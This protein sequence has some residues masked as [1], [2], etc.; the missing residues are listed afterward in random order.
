MIPL[1][2]K[3]VR[4]PLKLDDLGEIS[5]VM[6]SKST[7]KKLKFYIQQEKERVTDPTKISLPRICWNFCRNKIIADL[8]I[9][10]FWIGSEFVTLVR[11]LISNNFSHKGSFQ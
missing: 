10:L 1:I 8:I 6:K 2:W 5:E 3:G 9:C 11:F 7:L 4:N